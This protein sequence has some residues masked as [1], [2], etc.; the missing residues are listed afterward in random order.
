MTSI[1][2]PAFALVL[3]GSLAVAL[4]TVSLF[5]VG[6]RLLAAPPAEAVVAPDEA[7]VNDEGEDDP[8]TPPATRPVGASIGAFVAFALATLVAIAGVVLIVL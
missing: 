6:G 2:W 7:D 1:E 3:V 4:V 5:A 8:I